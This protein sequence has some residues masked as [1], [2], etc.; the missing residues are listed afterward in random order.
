MGKS[1]VVMLFLLAFGPNGGEPSGHK[2][3]LLPPA[4]KDEP[5]SSRGAAVPERDEAA[6]DQAAEDLPS[7]PPEIRIDKPPATPPPQPDPL[8][9]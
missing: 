8:E 1:T 9:P 3:E 7:M 5:L 6:A 4:V 2:E